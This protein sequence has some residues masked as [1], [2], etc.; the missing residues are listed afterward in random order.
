MLRRITENWIGAVV[1]FWLALGLF[2]RLTSSAVIAPVERSVNWVV[3]NSVKPIAFPVDGTYGLENEA[4]QFWMSKSNL[5]FILR[6]PLLVPIKLE[7]R[8]ISGPNPC[9]NPTRFVTA[10]VADAASMWIVEDDRTV[11]IASQ[12]EAGGSSKIRLTY[13]GSSCLIDSDPRLF[14]GSVEKITTTWKLLG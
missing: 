9:G 2:V 5:V 13:S 6:N 8:V 7:A 12:L 1:V 3:E 14:W 11:L 4:G 10:K